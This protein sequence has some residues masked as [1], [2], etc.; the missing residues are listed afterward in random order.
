VGLYFA[1]PLALQGAKTFY[2]LTAFDCPK[3]NWI[4]KQDNIGLMLTAIPVNFSFG[5]KEYLGRWLTVAVI[6][7]ARECR[8]GDG[9]GCG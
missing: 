7:V 1:P 3:Q 6:N 9:H 8:S 4:D 5:P 2:L